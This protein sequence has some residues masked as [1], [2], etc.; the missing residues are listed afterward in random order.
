MLILAMVTL[1]PSSAAISSSAG[2]IIRHG[3]HHSA[4]KSTSTGLSAPSTSVAKLWSVTVLVAMAANL[5]RWVGGAYGDSA[6]RCSTGQ[7]RTAAA[8]RCR[9]APIGPR[10]RGRSP[11]A[12]RHKPPSARGG[13]PG[14]APSPAGARPVL[15]SMTETRPSSTSSRS[16]VPAT[17]RPSAAS[18]R[19]APRPASRARTG[20]ES[21]VGEDRADEVGDLLRARRRRRPRPIARASAARPPR[22]APA[23][24]RA[25]ARAAGGSAIPRRAAAR[26]LG[27][28]RRR[29]LAVLG[30]RRRRQRPRR[31]ALGR[32]RAARPVG[33]RRPARSRPRRLRPAARRR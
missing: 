14:S 25:A 26:M 1:S 16:T 12:P 33:H 11:P 31:A 2:A 8:R 6:A 19:S 7:A 23:R 5:L 17:T 24:P 30:H 28:R 13:R 22:A 3:P 21:R 18:R 27:A 20:R 4:Q 9:A 10:G 32:R 29:G 15:K